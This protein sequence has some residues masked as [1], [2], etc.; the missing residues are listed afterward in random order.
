MSTVDDKSN[1]S[2][3]EVDEKSNKSKTVFH[4]LNKQFSEIWTQFTDC[5][6]KESVHAFKTKEGT[7][8][9]TTFSPDLTVLKVSYGKEVLQFSL[10]VG[11][12]GK[13]ATF[14]EVV[15]EENC[16]SSDENDGTF[17]DEVLKLKQGEFFPVMKKEGFWP[18]HQSTDIGHAR[19]MLTTKRGS[20]VNVV[21]DDEGFLVVRLCPVDNDEVTVHFSLD[22]SGG[23][24]FHTPLSITD[25]LVEVRD[26][27]EHGQDYS[28]SPDESGSERKSRLDQSAKG[29]DESGVFSG[30]DSG[31]DQSAKGSD[32]SGAVSGDDSG[33]DQ[34]AKGS[35]V[36]SVSSGD[37]S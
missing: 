17:S 34:S 6:R 24:S 21:H 16:R 13:V 35:D 19:P 33:L 18:F 31:S 7:V 36:S 10:T 23:I 32:A 29:S 22:V 26:D 37:D 1:K 9:R 20:T 5:G 14:V 11:S 4:Y 27:G 15:D 30:D 8:V 28:E 2:K 25:R 3:T 12:E